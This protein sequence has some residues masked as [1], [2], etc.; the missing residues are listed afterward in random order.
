MSFITG[1]LLIDAPASA[2]NNVGKLE[3]SRYENAVGVKLIRSREGSYP[4][5]SAQA[6][7]YWLRDTL[8]KQELEW[9]ASPIYR[10]KSVAYT[11]ADPIDYWDDDLF[12]GDIR[13]SE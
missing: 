9:K 12:G 7:R 5:V 10:E 3:G 4:Y 13:S 6:F 11:Y 1:L 2:L 8:Q